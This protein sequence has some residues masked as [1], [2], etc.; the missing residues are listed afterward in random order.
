MDC[1]LGRTLKFCILLLKKRTAVWVHVLE[2][3]ATKLDI[4]RQK[5]S[6]KFTIIISWKNVPHVSFDIT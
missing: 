1:H 5:V 2:T 3:F 6:L 4:E